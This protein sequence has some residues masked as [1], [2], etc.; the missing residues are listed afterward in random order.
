MLIVDLPTIAPSF[1]NSTHRYMG[2]SSGDL[3][4]EQ[5]FSVDG[6]IDSP[7]DSG[8]P[9]PDDDD[10]SLGMHFVCYLFLCPELPIY[11][12]VYF[13]MMFILSCPVSSVKMC[14]EFLGTGCSNWWDITISSFDGGQGNCM[15]FYSTEPEC[16][17]IS[18]TVILTTLQLTTYIY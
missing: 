6:V 13:I 14:E 9:S 12:D 16:K 3:R 4:L 8:G 10:G 2:A 1:S 11:H 15:Q 18:I 17:V 7:P 5:S